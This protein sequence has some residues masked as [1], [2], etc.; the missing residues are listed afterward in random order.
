MV[1]GTPSINTSRTDPYGKFACETSNGINLPSASMV[2]VALAMVFSAFG[3]HTPMVHSAWLMSVN[4]TE[5][6]VGMYFLN[7][8]LSRPPSNA[9]VITRKCSWPRRMMVRSPRNPPP[10]VSNGVYTERPTATSTLFTQTYC[11]KSTT[12]GPSKSNSLNAVRSTMPTD[13]RICMCSALVI[14]DHQ[15]ASHSCSRGAHTSGNLSTS[16][17]FDANHCGRSQPRAS[18]N[19]APSASSRG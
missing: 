15:R 13:S 6:S 17:A 4:V 5:P 14:G 9:P 16:F 19:V 12:P 11:K 10:G 18:K 7:Q 3:P 8:Y 1:A 2:C